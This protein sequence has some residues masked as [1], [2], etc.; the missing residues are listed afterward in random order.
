MT[1]TPTPSPP[2]TPTPRPRC[3]SRIADARKRVGEVELSD[4]ALLR[5]AEVCAA[6][7]VDGFRADIVMA[8][9]AAA[10]A[11]WCGRDSVVLED[12]EVAARLALPH[13]RRRNPFDSP[14]L[15]DDLLQD[16][17]GDDDLDPDDDPEPD[18]DPDPAP[19]TPGRPTVRRLPEP[20]P[21]DVRATAP[22]PRPPGPAPPRPARVAPYRARLFTVRGTGA[23]TAGRRSRAVTETGRR[24]GAERP[25]GAGGALHLVETIRAAVPHQH[26][27]GRVDGPAA[28]SGRGPAGRRPRGTR[29]QPGALLRRR[30]RLDGGAQA[31][32]AG[33]DRGPQPAARRL[34]A[35]GQGRVGDLPRRPGRPRAAADQLGR[36]GR[37]PARG[38]A[39]RWPD[40]AGRGPARGGQGARA[41]TDPRP[42]PP[43]A[44][45]RRHR[46]PGDRRQ[47]T[48][49]SARAPWPPR[50]A[51]TGV[52]SVVVDCESGPMRMG[53]ARTSPT[54]S[55][56]EHVPV[57]E[58]SAEALVRAARGSA[59]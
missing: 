29:V 49:S 58:V 12:I 22:P 18:P 2:P 9:T 34:P 10:H 42:A 27:R 21:Q 3:E 24:V 45:R 54:T 59:A 38:P 33:E 23:G 48:P 44:A 20:P 37:R 40:A 39:G 30:V 46:R 35:A 17:L 1:P 14:G 6:F 19:P 26:G 11:A 36:R 16:A 28:A 56:R 13:R 52:A 53:L 15:D 32:G 8:R 57:A 47:R 43:T 50:L 51:R 5:I 31:D 25:T 4:A 55:A 41:R 7:E